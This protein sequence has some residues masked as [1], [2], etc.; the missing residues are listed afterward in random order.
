MPTWPLT[1]PQDLL[2]AGQLVSYFQES[3]P[4][5][6]VRTEMD[7]GPAQ[8]R[9]RFTA[10]VRPFAGSMHMTKSQTAILDDF[11]LTEVKGGSLSFTWKHPRIESPVTVRFVK[12]PTYRAI[13]A[14]IFEV[15][16][17]MEILP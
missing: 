8:P 10:A 17:D 12:P 11:F 1:L 14:G 9:R 13:G 6:V 4:D 5:E 15:G 16:L 2:I 3:A 7:A